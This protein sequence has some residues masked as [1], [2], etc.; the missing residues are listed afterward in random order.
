MDRIRD[1]YCN[2][3]FGRR[4]DLANAEIIDESNYSITIKTEEEGE[5]LTATFDSPEEKEKMKSEWT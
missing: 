4:Y 1:L 2:G 5:I 3:Y